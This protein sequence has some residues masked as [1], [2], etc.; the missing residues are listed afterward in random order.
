MLFEGVKVA[1]R[2]SLI[3]GNMMQTAP[4]V[5]AFSG[6]TVTLSNVTCNG[7]EGIVP[8]VMAHNTSTITISDSAFN[9]NLGTIAGAIHI[10]TGSK[11]SLNTVMFMNNRAEHDGQTASSGALRISGGTSG[12][13]TGC[14]F[15]NNTG[16]RGGALQVRISCMRA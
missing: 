12:T 7:N 11:I 16:L 2:D 3:S 13:I 9:G 10:T 15:V 6:S 5:L 1:I 14:N 4:G 8:C